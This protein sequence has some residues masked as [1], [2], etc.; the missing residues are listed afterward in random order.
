M[1]RSGVTYYYHLNGHGD[2]IA[3]SDEL[4][5]I[6]AQYDYDAWGNILSQSGSMATEN[7][8]GYA[9]YYY[10]EETGLYYLRARYYDPEIGR[11]IRRDTVQKIN[12]YAYAENNPVML[13]DPIGYSPS[14]VFK[15]IY[16]TFNDLN[17]AE[18]RL[19]W[20]NPWKAW[21]AYNVA[22]QAAAKIRQRFPNTIADT[23]RHVYWNALIIKHTGWNCAYKWANAH[24]E[25]LRQLNIEEEMD[26][27]NNRKGRFIA[28]N[29][30]NTSDSELAE[31]VYEALVEGQL[32]YIRDGKVV[33]TTLLPVNWNNVL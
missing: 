19:L 23:F 3:L 20:S 11:F 18:K 2:V 8:Y 25:K 13:I 30:P 14:T 16:D 5:N 1:T 32:N 7:P 27:Y 4:G 29:N 28:L 10:D 33:S 9:G 21:L 26:L 31:L 6:V 17:K 12:Q 24:Q 15:N 22:N